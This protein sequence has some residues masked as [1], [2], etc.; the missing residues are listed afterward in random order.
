MKIIIAKHEKHQIALPMDG[1]LAN[2]RMIDVFI[3]FLNE[4]NSKPHCAITYPLTGWELEL[5]CNNLSY[6]HLFRF[7]RCKI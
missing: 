7:V 1:R 5:F 2:S 4:H 6:K 3:D